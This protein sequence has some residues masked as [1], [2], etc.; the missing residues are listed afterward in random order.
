MQLFKYSYMLLLLSDAH[1]RFGTFCGVW[2]PLADTNDIQGRQLDQWMQSFA[3]A[4]HVDK[5]MAEHH[6]MGHAPL[7][8]TTRQKGMRQTRYVPHG[9][10][11]PR[12]KSAAAPVRA[13]APDDSFSWLA[14]A[15]YKS[16]Y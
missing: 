14:P 12:P 11:K 5:Q 3:E 9:R 16:I 10:T 1:N 15:G 4:K 6:M 2:G 8:S 13:W 7:P